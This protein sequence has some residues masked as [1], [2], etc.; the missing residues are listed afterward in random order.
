MLFLKNIEAFFFLPILEK[1]DRQWP[2]VLWETA[3]HVV[4]A[5]T[6]HCLSGKAGTKCIKEYEYTQYFFILQFNSFK[7][8]LLVALKALSVCFHFS[9]H[10]TVKK[11]KLRTSLKHIHKDF[12]I[13]KKKIILK[14]LIFYQEI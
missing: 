14:L 11:S 5:L 13:K 1:H 6:S 8:D 7:T 9:V 10:Q 4:G 2:W 12:I 3:S